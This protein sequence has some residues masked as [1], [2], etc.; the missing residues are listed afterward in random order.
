MSVVVRKLIAKEL[1][2]N[3]WFV[4]GGAIA[5]IVSAGLACL[6][7]M[8]FNVGALM[9]MTTIVALGVMLAIYGVMNERKGQSLQFV[10]SLPLSPADYVR[11]KLT[12]LLFSFLIMWAVA[13]AAAITLVLATDVP[14]GMLPYVVCLSVFLL[15]NF[16]L[17][18]CGALHATTE[19]VVTASI[20]VTNML[21][22][23]YMFGV[24]TIPGLG[25]HIFDAKP[26]WNDTVFTIL[27]VEFCVIA[28]ALTLPFVFAARR[29]DFL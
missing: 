2:V 16:T 22:S 6:G 7:R 12:G 8:A 20:V 1:L 15:A 10:L 3:R 29:R 21:V 17:V 24:A 11:A 4:V 18:L 27:I 19:A 26:A 9:W 5:G 13:V 23:V 25:D 14:D 28:I